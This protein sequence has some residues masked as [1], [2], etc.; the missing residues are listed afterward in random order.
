MN[1]KILQKKEN[2]D[3]SNSY[4]IQLP[5]EEVIYMGFILESLEGWCHYTTVN[6]KDSVML[7]EVIKDFKS[8]FEELLTRLELLNI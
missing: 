2:L 3:Q 6:K 4:L 1:L 5:R 8:S 7:V